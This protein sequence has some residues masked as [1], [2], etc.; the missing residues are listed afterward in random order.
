VGLQ[1]SVFY[2][3]DSAHDPYSTGNADFEHIGSVEE[4]EAV[5]EGSVW[6]NFERLAAFIFEKNG[7]TVSVGTVK[8]KNRQRRQYDV[9]AK[10][11]G[12]TL[13]V[14]CKRWSGGRYR[15]SAL[16]RAVVQHRERA[17]FYESIM[18]GN[19]VPIIVTLIEEEI[20]IFEGIPL[21]PVHRLNAFIG[22]LDSYT[23]EF[24]CAEFEV[25][26]LPFEE[27]LSEE[28]G[29]LPETVERNAFP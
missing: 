23:D 6:Q 5:S 19:A 27:D 26:D 29:E 13:L 14:E 21:V 18:N 20:R 22:E 11:N 1:R 2:I 25:E 3:A 4:L 10:K 12:R 17:L 24:S 8:T 16:R 9:I 28:E 15:L 7:F